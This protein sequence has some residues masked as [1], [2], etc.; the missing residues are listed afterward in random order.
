MSKRPVR[1]RERRAEWPVRIYQLGEEPPENLSAITTAEERVEMVRLLSLRM[2]E[3][4]GQPLPSY[5]RAAMP[6]RVITPG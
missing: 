2:W 1:A 5:P 3:L 4:S 6:V